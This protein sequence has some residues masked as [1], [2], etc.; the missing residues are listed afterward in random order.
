[1]AWSK[2]CTKCGEAKPTSDFA[3]DASRK[4]GLQVWCKACNREYRQTNRQKIAEYQ[5]EYGNEYRTAN[6]DRLAEYQHEY[7][8]VNAD[9]VQKYYRSPEYRMARK[10]RLHQRRSL[11]RHN[12]GRYTAADIEAIKVGQTNKRGEVCCWWCNEPMQEWHIDH[13]IPLAKGG[14]NDARNLCLAHAKCNLSKGSKLPAEF[15]G[16]LI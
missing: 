2:P 9:K 14:T 8:L 7:R 12:S 6:S 1:M 15:I 11:M 13:R 4:D 10:A 3:K 16:R 5:R